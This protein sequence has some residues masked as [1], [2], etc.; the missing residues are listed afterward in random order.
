MPLNTNVLRTCLL[1]YLGHL[2]AIFLYD[3][4]TR[5][6]VK[7]FFHKFEW[8]H[9]LSAL[10]GISLFIV[11]VGQIWFISDPDKSTK[12][13]LIMAAASL[14][15]LQFMLFFLGRNAYRFKSN[16]HLQQFTEEL[17]NFILQNLITCIALIF[18]FLIRAN[19][20]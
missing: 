1:V 5:N 15:F 18:I 11:I 6:C 14:A 13:R 16:V 3:T 12:S 2:T 4:I 10:S 7:F 9:L 19:L 20:M 17:S 8:L